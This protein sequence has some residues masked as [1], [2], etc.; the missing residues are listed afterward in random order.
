MAWSQRVHPD[1]RIGSPP[2]PRPAP[3]H[4]VEADPRRLVDHERTPRAVGVDGTQAGGEPGDASG[5]VGRSV[6]RID[7]H[8]HITVAP[9]GAR[10]LGH[11]PESGSVEY[12][13]GGRIRRQV[14]PVLALTGAGQAPVGQIPEGSGDGRRRR[15]GARRADPGHPWDDDTGAIVSPVG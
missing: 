4:R 3:P 13:E 10:L 7:D 2:L 9:V 1:G 8:H 12:R 5:G 15:R 6:H 14:R 11:D